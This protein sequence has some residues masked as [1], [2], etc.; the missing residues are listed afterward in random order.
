MGYNL[1]GPD[2]NTACAK[3]KTLW[4]NTSQGASQIRQKLCDEGRKEMKI[5]WKA[6][7]S[8]G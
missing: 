8:C 4:W 3:A 1:P 6:Q 2:L 5:G 7:G